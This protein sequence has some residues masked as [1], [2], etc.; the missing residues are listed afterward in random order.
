[1]FEEVGNINQ[2]SFYSDLTEAGGL[3]PAIQTQLNAIGSPLTVKKADPE[4]SGSLPFDCEVIEEKQRFSQINIA[5]HQRLFIVDFWDRGVF[6]AQSSTPMLPKVAEAINAWI[7]EESSCGELQ[8]KFPFVSVE[9]TEEFHE[10]GAAAEVERK[11][12]ALYRSVKSDDSKA[13]LAPLVEKAMKVPALRQLFPFTSVVW[14]C[15]SRCTGHPFSGDCPS[16]CS[17]SWIPDEEA[18]PTPEQRAALGP[19]KPYTVADSNRHF[20]GEGDVAVAIELILQHLPPNCGP[21]IQG[22][23]DYL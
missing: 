14:L 16:V 17:S 11:W 8:R 3:G 13:E 20:L 2:S 22:T 5:K 19:I 21:A 4:F 6:L 9:S 18:R 15:F 23:A 1:M 12:Q 10:Q 7:A